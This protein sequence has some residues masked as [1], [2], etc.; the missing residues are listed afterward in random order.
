MRDRSGK[1]AIR[2]AP[3]QCGAQVLR[4]G[5]RVYLMGILNVTPDSFSDGGRFLDGKMAMEHA[6]KMVE[7]GADLIDVGGESSRPG[8]DPVSEKEE[9]SRV[10]PV[11]EALVKY[12]V[13]PISI[14]TTKAVVA[15]EAMDAG[16]SL[17]NDISAM[18]ADPAMAKVAAAS[19]VPVV[20]MH[21]RGTP[22]S[23]QSVP[24]HYD[25]VV[26]DIGK[27][28]S[29]RISDIESAVS[30]EKIIVDP[31]IGFGKTPQHNLTILHR[32]S[33]FASLG[34][35]LMVG[36]SRKA[37]V[38]AVLGVDVSERMYGTAAAV[39]AAVAGG[40]HILRVHDVLPMRQVADMA[41]A[42]AREEIPPKHSAER[43]A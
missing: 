7:D 1:K 42:I 16:A 4:F 28:L 37:F 18:S 19:G 8:S 13:A 34:Q 22:K 27:Y 41:W 23:M 24:I 26:K 17:I 15:K 29:K 9:L 32:I 20:L 33:E 10:I 36:P 11:I 3:I 38:G 43:V 40:A 25:D 35:P 14:D 5:E 30:R 6:L 2:P 39:A 21:M 31:G 12:T